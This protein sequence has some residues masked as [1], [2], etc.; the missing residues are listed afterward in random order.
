MEKSGNFVVT[1]KVERLEDVAEAR[2]VV[3]EELKEWL[4][5]EVW[6]GE[7]ALPEGCIEVECVEGEGFLVKGKV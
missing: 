6:R 7:V 4:W 5:R 1:R 2:M 3:A